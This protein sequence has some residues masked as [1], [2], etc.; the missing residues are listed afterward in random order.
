MKRT[1]GYLFLVITAVFNGQIFATGSDDFYGQP[2]EGAVFCPTPNNLSSAPFPSPR[3]RAQAYRQRALEKAMPV[4]RLA[5]I[6]NN[7]DVATQLLLEG[8]NPLTILDISDSIE[9]LTGFVDFLLT[10]GFDTK[11][12][13]LF[14]NKM[15]TLAQLLAEFSLFR[16]DI[17]PLIELL[18]KKGKRKK[19]MRRR[20]SRCPG[21][22]G[23]PTQDAEN[24]FGQDVNSEG[25][26][27]GSDSKYSDSGE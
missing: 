16:E 15:L 20:L 27:E 22:T 18:A 11:K 2:Q 13:Y 21:F 1:L 25:E 5:Y 19:S 14:N 17:T 12:Q 3:S 10:V 26:E 8:E 4:L 7:N 24:P 6:E 9:E 23:K